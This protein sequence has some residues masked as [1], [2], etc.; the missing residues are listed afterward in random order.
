MTFINTAS[1]SVVDMIIL[2]SIAVTLLSVNPVWANENQQQAK[3]EFSIPALPLNEAINSFIE[4][5]GWQVGFVTAQTKGVQS[6]AV[7]GEYT[8]EQALKKLLEGTDI[9]YQVVEENSITLQKR[10]A[11]GITTE[12]L[13]A[14]APKENYPETVI[15]SAEYDGPVEQEDLM[16]SGRE[17]SGYNILDSSTATKT[18]TPI[19]DT[20]LSIQV[21]SRAVMDDQQVIRVED[22]VKNISGVQKNF[23]FGNLRENFTIRGFSTDS[24]I[25]R[26]GVRLPRSSFE[27]SHLQQIEVLKGA[28]SALYGRIQP[29]GLIN[30]V[31]KQPLDDARYSLQQQFGSYDLYRTTLDAT[32]PLMEDLSYRVNFAYLN[33]GSFRDYVNQERIFFAPSV[34]WKLGERTRV[35]LALEYTNDDFVI[36]SGI[37][38]EGN[39]PANVNRSEF[40]GG[41]GDFA[42]HEGVLVDFNG[43]HE[44]NDNWSVKLAF[45]YEDRT[46]TESYLPVNDFGN[47][48]YHR[49][50]WQVE[51]PRQTYTTSLNLNG[52]IETYGIKHNMLLGGDFYRHEEDSDGCVGPGQGGTCLPWPPGTDGFD[53][54]NPRGNAAFNFDTSQFPSS[55]DYNW[56]APS[57]EEWY[58]I[59]FQDQITLFE[60][61]HIMGGGR[62][63]WIRQQNELRWEHL[64]FTTNE[65]SSLDFGFFSPRV[66]V[67]YQPWEWLSVFGNFSESVGSN[68]GRSFDGSVLEPE[69][70]IQY[71]VGA[72]TELWGGRFSG[73]L[74]FYHLTKENIQALDTVNSSDTSFYRTV[75]KALS[76]GIELDFSGQ[77]TDEISVIGSYSFIDARIT[78]DDQAPGNIG[79]RLANV[80]ENSGSLWIKYDFPFETVKGLTIGTGTFVSSYREGDNE[81]TF[82]LPG[83]VRWDA[84]V[85][86]Q[87]NAGL[88]RITT[89]LNVNNILDKTYYTASNTLDGSPRA[90]I[91]VAEPMMV[92]GSIKIE[93]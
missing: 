3:Q 26:N 28:S 9:Q 73:S 43:T 59:Y 31:T 71:E 68:I 52:K 18:D 76:Q 46:F 56:H 38:A 48:E 58:G 66:G 39:R 74:T 12:M 14:Q 2:P 42:T 10:T 61:L 51:N 88:T 90:G 35:N 64:F 55:A 63:D 34:S 91:S 85:A 53:P 20:P 41:E 1:K 87:F 50:L 21:I 13:L 57:M 67:L 93:Y 65:S 92:M 27:T 81:N 45:I 33:Q 70:G 29:G 23:S 40:M 86:Y 47:D 60:K 78:S 30:L 80:P 79:N 32:G 82:R 8:K 17:L 7:Q 24:Q 22:A 89:Q 6:K 25:Y 36:D 4:T 19:F 49:G 72:K 15:D 5:T 84:M 75:G 37:V 83:Y 11:K 54:Y 77:I 16:V 44:F 62:Y 69:T